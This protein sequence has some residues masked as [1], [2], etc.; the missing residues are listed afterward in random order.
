MRENSVLLLEQ[1]VVQGTRTRV[2]VSR[3]VLTRYMSDNE[4][5]IEKTS[6][7]HLSLCSMK[8]R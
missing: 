7:T 1:I 5:N 6:Y 2:A 8:L 3:T 4:K